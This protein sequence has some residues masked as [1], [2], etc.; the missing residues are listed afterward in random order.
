MRVRCCQ[1]SGSRRSC[2]EWGGSPA[3][4]CLGIQE[5]QALQAPSHHHP[6]PSPPSKTPLQ[7]PCCTTHLRGVLQVHQV[8][9]RHVP[10]LHLLLAREVKAQVKPGGLD[11]GVV[12]G[13]QHDLGDGQRA[14]YVLD[15]LQQAP[16]AWCWPVGQSDGLLEDG[17]ASLGMGSGQLA[18][19]LRPKRP[20]LTVRMEPRPLP[21]APAPMLANNQGP[22]PFLTWA[23]PKA[24]PGPCPGPPPPAPLL[25]PAVASPALALV[26]RHKR[27]LQIARPRAHRRR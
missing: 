8:R 15:R 20:Q 23:P 11:D 9:V 2:E 14:R 25:S 27:H 21:N 7:H 12:G 17:R 4:P 13:A 3:L 18:G 1:V 10:L 16:A 19:K 26:R 24:A 6:A 5:P 22:K